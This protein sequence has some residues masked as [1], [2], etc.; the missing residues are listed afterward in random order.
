[1]FPFLLVYI[2]IPFHLFELYSVS[3][4]SLY[5]YWPIHSI[6]TLSCNHINT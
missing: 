3:E 6:G 1:M 4:G 2:L 5:A